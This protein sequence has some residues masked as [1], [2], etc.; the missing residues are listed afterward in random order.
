MDKKIADIRKEYAQHT[1]DIS[2]VAKNP[3]NQFTQW[4]DQALKS[5][6]TEPN[7]MHLATLDKEGNPT[8]RIVLLKGIEDQNFV[9]Y[10][11]YNSHK[12]QEIEKHPFVSLT[13]FWPEL[14]RQVRVQGS[15]HKVSA[16]LSDTYFASRPRGSQIGAWVSPQSQTIESREM[17][18]KLNQDLTAKFEG[19]AIERP[20]HWGGYAV[21]PEK[22][23]FWQGRPNRL[24]DR[25]CYTKEVSS[26]KVERLAP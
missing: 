23:E 12:G 9:F 6:V 15:V 19:K 4:F 24:H 10:T 2:D 1:L 22:I 26:W 16:D 18:E 14:E 21:H 7:A 8:G 25:I 5:D 3:V 13:F 20:K 17:L 11:N